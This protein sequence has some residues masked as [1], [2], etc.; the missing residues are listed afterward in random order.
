MRYVALLRLDGFCTVYE[1]VEANSIEEA[2]NYFIA[3]LEKRERNES[4]ILLLEKY[5]RKY[6]MYL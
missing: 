4:D 6:D 1:D 3:Y 5:S 2:R